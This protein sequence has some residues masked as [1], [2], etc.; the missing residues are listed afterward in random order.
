MI[1]ERRF[2]K[3][4]FLLIFLLLSSVVTAHGAQWAKTYGGNYAHGPGQQWAN[5]IQQT[6][7]GGYIVAGASNSFGGLGFNFGWVLKLD[8]NGLVQWEKQ[9]GFGDGDE[10][11]CIRQTSDGRYIVAGRTYLMTNPSPRNQAWVFKLDPNGIAV[12]NWTFGGGEDDSANSVE[13]TFDNQYIVAGSTASFGTAG[14]KDIWVFKL[15]TN[16]V[17]LWQRTFGGAN[18]DEANSVRQTSDEGYIV[19]GSTSSFGSGNR[20]AWILKLDGTGIPQWQKT[21]GGSLSDEATSIQ[22]TSDGGYIVAGSTSSFGSGFSYAWILKLDENGVPGWQKQYGYGDG[23]VANSIQQT[24]DGGFI[25]AG[26][27]YLFVLPQRLNDAWVFKVDGNGTALW[28]KGFGGSDNDYANSIQQTSDGGYVV[29]GET[30]SYGEG[31]SSL[32]VLKIDGSG[33]IPTCPIAST[34]IASGANT[35]ASGISTSVTSGPGILQFPVA[36]PLTGSNT[37]ATV[38]TQ[39]L[40]LCSYSILPMSRAHGSGAETGTVDVTAPTG[41]EW[42]ATSNAAWITVTSGSNGTGNGTVSYS[43]SANGDTNSR[44]GTLTIAG[45]TFTVTQYPILLMSPSDQTSFDGCSFYFLPT[46]TWDP[47]ESFKSYEI[48]F[49]SRNTFDSISVKVKTSK[50]EIV[51]PSNTWKKILLI[52][53][54]QVFW[55]VVG[56]Q[57]DKTQAASNVFSILIEGAHEVENSQIS[58]TSKSSLPTLSWSNQCNKKFKVWFGSDGQFSEKKS[59]S[60]SL[61]DL[62]ETL[63]KGLTSS[64]WGSIR[65]L[66][67]DAAGGTIYWYVE[68]WD[69]LGRYAR[70]DVMSFVLTD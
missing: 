47:T 61:K 21:Y 57:A 10:I 16:G 11:N 45:Q 24:S 7:D 37:H 62:S 56:T 50:T 12:W 14:G 29:A 32:W 9:Y 51:I 44:T 53:S 67:G 59:F 64:Q 8:A 33:N 4:I 2:G 42:I 49:S 48:Q 35:T 30:D 1:T 41:C 69:G 19:A 70:T 38:D 13:Q 55:R 58:P 43:V 15:N 18:D 68:S 60:F 40:I 63:T 26:Y 52:P 54:R 3:A 34:L 66:A 39:C 6:A 20:D 36:S 22:Q 5:S 17:L 28:G 23:D 65:K 46:V 25:V 31:H 27:S